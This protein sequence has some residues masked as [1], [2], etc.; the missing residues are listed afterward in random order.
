MTT[1]YG[2]IFRLHF[3]IEAVLFRFFVIRL[4]YGGRRSRVFFTTVRFLKF[5]QALECFAT[6]RNFILSLQSSQAAGA[7]QISTTEQAKHRSG[8]FHFLRAEFLQK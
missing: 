8:A 1:C 2:E 3:F 4:G 6:S 7:G 5:L